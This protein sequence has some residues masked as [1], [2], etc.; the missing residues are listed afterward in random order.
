MKRRQTCMHLGW[1]NEQSNNTSP[2][3]RKLHQGKL[4]TRHSTDSLVHPDGLLI[5]SAI[6]VAQYTLYYPSGWQSPTLGFSDTRAPWQ[7]MFSEMQ[8]QR[9]PIVARNRT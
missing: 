7:E 2:Y 6:V 4:R 8:F 3:E 1:L 5:V 9:I